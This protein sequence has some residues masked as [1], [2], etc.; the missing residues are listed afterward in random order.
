MSELAKHKK[1]RHMLDVHVCKLCVVIL[2]IKE[3]RKKIFFLLSVPFLYF[4]EWVRE[5]GGK[6]KLNLIELITCICVCVCVCARIC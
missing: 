4:I 3:N 2:R 1:H 6:K 5:R